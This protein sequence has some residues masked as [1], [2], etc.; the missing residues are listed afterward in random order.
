MGWVGALI[1]IVVLVVVFAKKPPAKDSISE[2]SEVLPYKKKD[3]LLSKGDR[4][5]FNALNQL[6]GSRGYYVFAKV[7]MG[8]ILYLPNNTEKR[9][10]YW[11]KIQGKSIDFLICDATYLRPR[12]AIEAGNSAN[13]KSDFV[14]QVF[15]AAGVPLVRVPKQ[16]TYSQESVE[17]ALSQTLSQLEAAATNESSR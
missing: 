6:L 12:F 2:H 3:F 4:A 10:T 14:E 11:N 9:Q 17:Q 5:L 15:A 16:Q 1:V 7:R 13:N 8:D